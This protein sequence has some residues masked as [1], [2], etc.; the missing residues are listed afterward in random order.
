[1]QVHGNNPYAGIKHESHTT[2]FGI[3]IC[4]VIHLLFAGTIGIYYAF[5]SSNVSKI[6]SWFVSNGSCSALSKL[7]NFACD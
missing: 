7:N 3:A 4:S 5:L 1:M 6:Q 2:K